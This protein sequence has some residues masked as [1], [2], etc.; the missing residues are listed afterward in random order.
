VRREGRETR[1]RER[2]SHKV[3]E[4]YSM[5]TGP[6]APLAHAAP[7]L[8]PK[9]IPMAHI[10]PIS[11]WTHLT[12]GTVSIFFTRQDCIP[13]Y[14]YLWQLVPDTHHPL[15]EKIAPLDTFVS[16]P[17]H[18]KP[19]PSSFRLPYLWEKTLM[20]VC[21]FLSLHMSVCFSLFVCVC[22]FLSLCVCVF[23]CG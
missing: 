1:W 20:C 2:V 13:L 5:E 19:L 12:H 3:T 17:S 14:Y 11:L 15:C 6:L 4:V 10:W 8:T 16:L 22:V 7:F 9:L 21:V 23:L 18:L